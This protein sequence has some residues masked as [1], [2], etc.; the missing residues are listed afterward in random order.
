VHV[1]IIRPSQPLRG[2]EW[3]GKTCRQKRMSFRPKAHYKW[4]EVEKSALKAD[5]SARPRG[6][7]RGDKKRPTILSILLKACPERS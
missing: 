4:A 7:G 3:I 1:K 5:L 6:L 2:G